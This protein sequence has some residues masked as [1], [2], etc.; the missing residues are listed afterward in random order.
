MITRI[1]SGMLGFRNKNS[2]HSSKFEMLRLVSDFIYNVYYKLKQW[3]NPPKPK[4]IG[5]QRCVCG[6]LFVSARC[7]CGREL[8]DAREAIRLTRR[9]ESSSGNSSAQQ[10]RRLGKGPRASE[11]PPLPVL[12]EHRREGLDSPPACR[13]RQLSAPQMPTLEAG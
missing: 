9:C 13:R 5:L 3:V 6:R 10:Y 7:V 1:S 4:K 11:L 12:R 8:W 2:V